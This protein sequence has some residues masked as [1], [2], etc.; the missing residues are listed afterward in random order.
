[1]T[2]EVKETLKTLR[3]RCITMIKR[4]MCII[5]FVFVSSPVTGFSLDEIDS[6]LHANLRGYD[7][8]L[9]SI[10]SGLG[11]WLEV[12]YKVCSN[13]TIYVI[14]NDD[15]NSPGRDDG[16]YII[17]GPFDPENRALWVIFTLLVHKGKK[18][19]FYYKFTYNGEE[20]T[21]DNFTFK[22]NDMTEDQAKKMFLEIINSPS[23]KA[24]KDW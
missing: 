14:R 13:H 8:P 6:K 5:G 23:A 24:W 2:G 1:M 22:N 11:D 16:C 9:G 20:F 18:T 10:I 17:Y 4:L 15:P 7:M 3:E 21:L 12:N 19:E